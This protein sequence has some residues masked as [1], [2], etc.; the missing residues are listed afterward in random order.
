MAKL[1][2]RFLFITTSRADY[3]HQRYLIKE[4]LK[5]KKITF[6]LLV[7]G[8]HF[9]KSFGNS[10]KEIIRDKIKIDYKIKINSSLIKEKI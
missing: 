1:K 6:E 2:K 4:A 10:Y 8:S 7:S 3:S 5:S 9:S